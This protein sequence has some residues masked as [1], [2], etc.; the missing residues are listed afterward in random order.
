MDIVCGKCGR[1][2]TSIEACENH[3]S[4]CKG[5]KST[6]L[7]FYPIS[8]IPKEDYIELIRIMLKYDRI[9]KE[10]EGST[11]KK[12]WWAFLVFLLVVFLVGLTVYLVIGGH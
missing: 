4:E 10:K 9:V 3:I 12:T 1:H 6:P 5:Y 11:T 2:F 8:S 7:R